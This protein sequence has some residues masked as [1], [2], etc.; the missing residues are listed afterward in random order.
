M[1]SRPRLRRRGAFVSL[2]LLLVLGALTGVS[3]V[4]PLFGVSSSGAAL[5]GIHKIKHVVMI[6]QENRSFDSYFGT[7]PGANGIPMANGEPSVCIPDPNSGGCR[8]PYP[9]HIDDNG[10]GP[11]GGPAAKQDIDGGKMDGFIA[12]A[13]D[14]LTGCV[15]PTNP[16]CQN[17]P[18]DVLGYH[19]QS[20]IPNYWKYA[21]N[22]VLQD[23]MFESVAS[24]SLP[25]HL[26][27]V[28]EWSAVCTKRN[29]PSSCRN[30]LE[31]PGP[32]PP[33]DHT[34]RPYGS[35]GTPIYAWTDMTY[36]LHKYNVSWKYY[37]VTG[38]EPDCQNAN[39]LTCVPG[40]QD[41]VTPGIWNPLPY[42]DTVNNDKQLGNIQSVSNLY[43]DAKRGTL[44]SVSWVV[45]SGAVSEHP[46]S[47][48][49]AGQ[50]YVTSLINAIMSGPDWDS[51]AI[52]LGWDDW[53]GMY[54]HVVPPNVDANGYGLRVP[55]MVISP[56]AK[57]G[58]IDHQT[59]SFDAYSK[60]IED[61]FISSRRLDPKTDG[62][63]DPRPD[64]RERAS[65]LGDLNSDFDFT[66][67][68]RPPMLLPVHPTTTLVPTVPFSPF[69]PKATSGN[70]QATLTW[71]EPTNDGGANIKGYVVTP[72]ING[73]AQ[74][75]I[76]FNT[77]A[78]TQIIT[79]L[80]NGK[81]YRFTVAAK[82]KIG[83]GYPSVPTAPRTIGIPL[84]PTAAIAAPGDASARVSWHAPPPGNLPGVFQYVVTPY[85]GTVALTPRTFKSAATTETIT[86]LTNGNAYN[87][88]VAAVN[89]NGIGP[90]SEITNN[91]VVGSPLAPTDVIAT[92][93][94]RGVAVSWHP[95][96]STN[97]A[98]ITGY[99]VTPYLGS[100]ARAARNFGGHTT[101]ATMT[102]LQ[103]GTSY[104][105]KV[106]A[107]NSRGTSPR[108]HASNPA[109]AG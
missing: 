77:A 66:Q 38:S 60:F 76:R 33:H 63:P 107:S 17:G 7:Y 58:V 45:P 80:T 6:M 48:V 72:S 20:D 108:S 102:G 99:V 22:F 37:V 93:D 71:R 67:A 15:D 89:I 75:P 50:S 59:L 96:A 46:P 35:A 40:Q 109:T 43:K 106:S 9:D 12:S 29:V 5:T 54:D 100:K 64:V 73:V 88:V 53:G 97:G 11:H 87:F 98:R 56:Y 82:N 10:G 81:T 83:V 47:S 94:P 103:A 78:T 44:P 24:W 19:T 14:G 65:I 36:L 41:A 31:R 90:H 28:S 23:R 61:D 18:I 69:S 92:Q 32:K 30:E 21:Q 95:P 13:E 52:F 49:S 55:A 3:R 62:R 1:R 51:T 104:T 101:Q 8:K 84:A 16:N 68:P 79:G 105:F 74:T 27:Q 70:G 85:L 86:G 25:E 4:V 2:S 42:F 34:E 91:V 26:Y 57:K 39:A